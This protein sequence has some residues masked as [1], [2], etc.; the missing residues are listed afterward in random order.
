MYEVTLVVSNSV[1]PWTIATRLL[2]P[3]DFP[4]K[5]TGVGYHF[6]FQGIFP[7]QGLN[8]HRLVLLYWQTGSLPLLINAY[9]PTK[10]Y[11]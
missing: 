11:A 3:W 10:L 1:I 6:L 7:T 9:T 5:N 2:C 8:P 4:S